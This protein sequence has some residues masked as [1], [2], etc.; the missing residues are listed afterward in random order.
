M[1]NVDCNQLSCDVNTE[2]LGFELQNTF[3]NVELK[4][5]FSCSYAFLKILKVLLETVS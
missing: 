2:N 3:C 1:V 5:Y 4:T